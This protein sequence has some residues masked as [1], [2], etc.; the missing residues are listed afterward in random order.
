MFSGE[1]ATLIGG[2]YKS[3]YIQFGGMPGLARIGLDEEDVRE[4]QADILNTVLLKD[5]IM[6]NQIRNVPFLQNLV[7][8]LADNTGK[9]ISANGIAKYMKSQG[10]S[11]T[12]T[13]SGFLKAMTNIIL[14]T[15]AYAMHYLEER[16]KEISKR[17][18]KIL[19]VRNLYGV[20]IHC[21]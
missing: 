21:M 7:R 6:R 18:L 19:F 14:K 17:L 5:V 1:L 15:M 16:G 8:F 3:I 20:V 13:E 2:R 12:S 4:Y 11:V 9:I 10:E